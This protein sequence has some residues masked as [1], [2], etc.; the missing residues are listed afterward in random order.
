MALVGV[1]VVLWYLLRQKDE[2]Q[3]KE[4]ASLKE[5]LVK[6]SDTTEL[7]IKEVTNRLWVKHDENS[8]SIQD[9]REKIAREHYV[10]QELDQRFDKI[11][12]S[13]KEGFA[14]IGGKIESLSTALLAHMQSEDN[15]K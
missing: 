5:S 10:K 4:I 14:S 7:K 3:A 15:R 8:H 9:L 1:F 13:L 6:A 2:S 11:E 12:L